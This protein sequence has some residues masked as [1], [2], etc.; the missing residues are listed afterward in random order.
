[1][2]GNGRSENFPQKDHQWNLKI[3][4]YFFFDRMQIYPVGRKKGD[5]FFF[6]V[7]HTS[8]TRCE[9]LCC[10]LLLL[11]VHTAWTKPTCRTV[12]YILFDAD[13]FFLY[14]FLKASTS[15]HFSGFFFLLFRVCP[16]WVSFSGLW[17]KKR[18][19]TQ[20]CLAT[21]VLNALW[22]THCTPLECKKEKKMLKNHSFL[23]SDNKTQYV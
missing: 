16:T 22:L 18:R 2:G 23:P 13:N 9:S 15:F 19:Q 4:E 7:A 10:L 12:F 6:S 20:N 17:M 1:M 8:W 21:I 14:W 11:T 5:F 3:K